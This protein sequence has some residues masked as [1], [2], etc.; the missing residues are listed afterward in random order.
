MLIGVTSLKKNISNLGFQTLVDHFHLTIS[1][2]MINDDH[3]QLC[4]LKFK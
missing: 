1:L 4:T 3:F 2:G